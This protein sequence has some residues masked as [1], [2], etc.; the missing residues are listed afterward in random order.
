EHARGKCRRTNR[1]RNLK[2][3]TVRLRT[4]RKVM[5]LD[6]ALKP[7]TLAHS[8]DVDETLAF[9]NIHQNAVARFQHTL[10]SLARG[11]TLPNTTSPTNLTGGR[12]C[13]A[14]CPRMGLVSFFSFT[15]STR[16]ICADS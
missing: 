8:D 2:H 16:P 4:T 7:A 3:R 12:L 6:D 9:E 1:T 11:V 15:N 10:G 13:L 14:K 5:P